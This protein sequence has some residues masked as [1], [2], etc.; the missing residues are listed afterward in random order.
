ML[1]A[2]TWA[3]ISEQYIND[4]FNSQPEANLSLQQQTAS[5]QEAYE[6]SQEALATF[7]AESQIDDFQRRITET[8]QMIDTLQSNRQSAFV[9][10][11][12]TERLTLRQYYDTQIELGQH[13]AAARALRS[14]IE[15]SDNPSNESNELALMLLKAEV[16]ASSENLP[17]NLQ[18]QVD[19]GSDESASSQRQ[20]AD[21]EALI[22]VIE[23][24]LQE[25][26][27]E[28]AEH[29]A[30]L[31]TGAGWDAEEGAPAQASDEGTTGSAAS[32]QNLDTALGD[33]QAELRQLQAELAREEGQQQELTRARDLA[34][35]TYSTLQ[36]KGVERGIAA[37]MKDVEVRFAA[38]AIEPFVP[39]GSGV[40]QSV[41]MAGLFGLFLGVGLA[42]FLQYLYPEYDS[43]AQVRAF[44][45]RLRR[46]DS[47]PDN[48]T[49]DLP[50]RAET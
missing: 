36:L 30:A 44:F 9:E 34:W 11:A 33:L 13:L 37:E 38:A 15:Q 41:A 25:I 46:K 26:E 21:L 10:W 40:F 7:M 14:Q 18:L 5:A 6:V 27:A 3:R 16:F 45:R 20:L 47:L 4:L 39:V 17:T 23:S 42:L 12:E 29:S 2:N 1:I 32:A 50:Q 19:L 43:S 28:I 22:D 35:D 8:G 24:R 49:E 48:S 31:L